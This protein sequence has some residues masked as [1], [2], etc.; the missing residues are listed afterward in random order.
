MMLNLLH[1]VPAESVQRLQKILYTYPTILQIVRPRK[2]KLGD[3]RLP[4][5][6]EKHRITINAMEDKDEFLFTLL[7]ELAHLFAFEKYGRKI[8][9]HGNE[10][11][12]EYRMFLLEFEDILGTHPRFNMEVTKLPARMSYPISLPENNA[13]LCVHH[14]EPGDE[15]IFNEKRKMKMLQKLRKYYL[16]KDLNNGKLYRVHPMGKVSKL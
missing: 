12:L 14:L 8:Q 6:G 15:F 9:P 13:Q 16:C 3:Y 5:K 1:W 4:P 2:T 11:K 10:W 7:H